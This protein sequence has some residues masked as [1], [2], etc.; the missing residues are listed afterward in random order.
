MKLAPWTALG[1]IV[2]FF[3][4][5]AA[6][7]NPDL[8]G[9]VIALD[10]TGIDRLEV[11]GGDI[12]VAFSEKSLPHALL[13]AD[14]FEDEAANP[15]VQV[16]RVGRTLRVRLLDVQDD[17]V[18]IVAPT[19]VRELV[20]DGGE[21]EARARVPQL[22]VR[23][24]GNV[25]WKG[26]AGSLHLVEF[27]P[28]AEECEVYGAIEFTIGEGDVASL[29]VRTRDGRVALDGDAKLGP[30]TLALGPLGQITL[31][32]SRRLPPVRV[33][34]LAPGPCAKVLAERAARK[35]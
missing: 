7:R 3:G 13:G 33:V 6:A 17:T 11:K 1:A 22:G 27:A 16:A 23:S 12:D 10:F 9:Q 34:D 24:H 25:S 31:E 18:T 32:N 35:G 8:D 2:L 26:D 4:M 5:A 30:T 21:I 14:A 15:R 28:D 20:L 29:Y 19:R